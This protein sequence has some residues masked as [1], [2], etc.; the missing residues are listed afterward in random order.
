[1]PH[2]LHNEEDFLTMTIDKLTLSLDEKI[3]YPD[4]M[5]KDKSFGYPNTMEL[6]VGCGIVGDRFAGKG[7][8]HI[9]MLDTDVAKS[10][11]GLEGLCTKKFTGNFLTTGL[12][13]KSLKLGQKFKAGSAEIE[14]IQNGKKCYPECPLVMAKTPCN[15]SKGSAFAKV[16][17]SGEVK[18]GDELIPIA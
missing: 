3:A 8:R 15:L 6:K 7:D 1:M 12:N 17:K 10:I 16:T 11:E 9:C 18:L 13:Y 5:K 4:K 2:K 14:I